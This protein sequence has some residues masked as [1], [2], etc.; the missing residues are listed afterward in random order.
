MQ[1]VANDKENSKFPL[2]SHFLI[3]QLL[4]VVA[5]QMG[6][7]SCQPPKGFPPRNHYTPEQALSWGREITRKKLPW[8]NPVPVGRVGRTWAPQVRVWQ[9]WAAENS[10]CRYYVNIGSYCQLLLSA[11]SEQLCGVQRSKSLYK[12]VVTFQSKRSTHKKYKHY[13]FFSNFYISS[14]WSLHLCFSLKNFCT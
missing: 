7:T 3:W 10:Y 11:G 14:R 8:C 1:H 2:S 5:T 6:T 4:C 13:L 9:T 12:V